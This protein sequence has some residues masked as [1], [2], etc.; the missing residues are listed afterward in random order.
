LSVG[1]MPEPDRIF[2]RYLA[3]DRV[4]FGFSRTAMPEV[5]SEPIAW[6]ASQLHQLRVTLGAF[7]PPASHPWLASIVPVEARQISR[8]LRIELDGKRIAQAYRRFE[9][10]AGA[11]VRIGSR[12]LG[13]PAAPRFSGEVVAA[14]RIEI[15]AANLAADLRGSGLPA[16]AHIFKLRLRL[17]RARPGSIEPLVVT[18]ATGQGDALGIEYLEGGRVRLLFDHWG[19]AL[20]HSEP[21]ALDLAVAHDFTI[22]FPWLAEP[23]GGRIERSGELRVEIGGEIVWREG[24]MGYWA[25][26]EEIAIGQNPIGGSHVGPRF[27]GALLSVERLAR[28]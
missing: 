8:L 3:G 13:S 18:G 27:S 11:R 2:V 23:H 9:P 19:A 22:H 15:Q 4:Q 21:L 24:T 26:P 7:L 14:R 5:V 1:E 10:V 16:P 20:L 6:N 28:E 17:P 25:D 12:S